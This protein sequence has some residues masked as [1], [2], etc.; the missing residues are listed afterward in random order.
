[1]STAPQILVFTDLDGSFLDHHTY[2]YTPAL[3]ALNRLKEKGAIILPATSKTLAEIKDLNLPFLFGDAIAEN[4]MVTIRNNQISTTK[5]YAEII[6]FIQTLPNTIKTCITGFND[7]TIDDIAKYTGLPQNQTALAKARDASEP[8]LW[9]GTD[10]DLKTLTT[11]ANTQNL[12]ITQGGRFYHL[13][14]QGG[15]DAAL[16]NYMAAY[17]AENPDKTTITIALGDGPNDAKMLSVVDYGIRIP[18][19]HGHD[20]TVNNPKGE[21]IAATS[22]G[23]A[24][25]NQ[26]ILHLLENLR[27]Q[28]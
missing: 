28:H 4:G 12:T 23:P 8:F 16:Q 24:G 21:I 6:A 22:P 7:M 19:K 27:L 25:W 17:H 14:G 1:M 13:M 26:S 10:D 9:S 5:S 3:P 11:L 18:N 2:D 15:K 20:F